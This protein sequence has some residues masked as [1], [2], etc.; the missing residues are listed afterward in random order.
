MDPELA[1]LRARRMA[2]LQER[3]GQASQQAEEAEQKQRQM[4]EQKR[5]I[6]HSILTQDALERLN[7][8]AI[9]KPQR[10]RQAESFV[11]RHAQMGRMGGGKITDEKLV[12]LLEESLKH[13]EPSGPTVRIQRRRDIDDD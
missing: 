3:N 1:E 8:L 10:A 4:E 2:E 5:I 9:V 6:L 12:E 11:L 13:S 7:R